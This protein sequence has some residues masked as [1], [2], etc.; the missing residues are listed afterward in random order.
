MID[1]YK[2]TDLKADKIAWGRGREKGSFA[3]HYLKE[4]TKYSIFTIYTDGKLCL[5]FGQLKPVLPEE[6]VNDFRT[7]IVSIPSLANIP[8]TPYPHVNIEDIFLNKLESLNQFKE[9]VIKFKN[10]I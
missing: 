6:T 5:N 3:F 10:Q 8:D 9:T 7:S 4:G 2:W 1:I